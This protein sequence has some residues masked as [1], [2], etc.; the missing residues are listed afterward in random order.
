MNRKFGAPAGAF[1]GVNGVQSGFELRTS[2]AMTPLNVFAA[3]ASASAFSG[4]GCFEQPGA[5][6]SSAMAMP[7]QVA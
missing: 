3:F 1:F 2:S 7:Q 6:N 4:A 5:A